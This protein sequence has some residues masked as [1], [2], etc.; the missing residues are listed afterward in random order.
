MDSHEDATACYELQMPEIHRT[1][2][3]QQPSCW[4]F[5]RKIERLPQKNSS[6]TVTV[7]IKP[8]R[9]AHLCVEQDLLCPWM[10]YTSWFELHRSQDERCSAQSSV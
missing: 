2:P 5:T 3:L 9:L 8:E 1:Q 4:D 7:T 6:A 10:C